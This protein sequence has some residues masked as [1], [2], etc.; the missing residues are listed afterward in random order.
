MSYSYFYVVTCHC[1][2][3]I[4][5]TRHCCL[6]FLVTRR[7][8]FR[9]FL[10]NMF[11]G[12]VW[13]VCHPYFSWSSICLVILM[14]SPPL[15]PPNGALCCGTSHLSLCIITAHHGNITMSQIRRRWSNLIFIYVTDNHFIFLYITVW[16]LTPFSVH[17]YCT[18]RK[19]YYESGTLC[20]FKFILKY[21][22]GI[23]YIVVQHY[24][25]FYASRITFCIVVRHCM[26][27]HAFDDSTLYCMLFHLPHFYFCGC[28]VHHSTP[29]VWHAL[30]P[31]L[32]CPWWRLA[33]FILGHRIQA[34]NE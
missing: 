33:H 32:S 18:S 12:A 28:G 20:I 27:C 24:M 16:H 30:H 22:M 13:C 3:S 5:F 8:L 14:I 26:M 31:F 11:V 29:D 1:Y 4:V 10:F 6:L 9:C 15:S 23:I 25:M 34:T 2:K 7:L 17:C 19:Y 21:V